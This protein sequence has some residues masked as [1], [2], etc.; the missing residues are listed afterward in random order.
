[1]DSLEAQEE[2]SQV[3]RQEVS[4][5]AQ[6]TVDSLEQ[7]LTARDPS[8]FP[9]SPLV[10]L[11]RARALILIVEEIADQSLI[12]FRQRLD[13]SGSTSLEEMYLP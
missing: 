12:L 11:I 6:E 8:L 5:L 4:S 9:V 13:H 2:G 10:G 1:V 3:T 7:C